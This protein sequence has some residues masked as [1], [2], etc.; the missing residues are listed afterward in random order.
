[1][2]ERL[3]RDFLQKQY[4]RTSPYIVTMIRSHNLLLAFAPKNC[5]EACKWL[6]RKNV[7]SE[8]LKKYE[9][10]KLKRKAV[11]II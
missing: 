11:E 4:R 5:I 9:L 1:M 10:L 6:S 2:L 8:G 3:K 7:Q